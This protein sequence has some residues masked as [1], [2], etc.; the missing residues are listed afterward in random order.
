M[1]DKIWIGEQ[2]MEIFKLW[3]HAKITLF[4]HNCTCENLVMVNY[5]KSIL[6]H[7]GES[8]LTAFTGQEDIQYGVFVNDL[9]DSIN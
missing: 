2:R 3:L 1:T 6:N 8:Y 9:I 5:Y 4:Q 7:L